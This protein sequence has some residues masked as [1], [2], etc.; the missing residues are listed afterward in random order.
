VLLYAVCSLEPEEGVET[1]AA[2]MG[3]HPGFSVEDPR[4]FLKDGA[5][6][7]VVAAGASGPVVMTRPDR[8]GMDGFFA[9][10]MRRQR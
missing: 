6:R 3:E 4:P 9:V 1:L 2:F 8:D 5:A 10:R 7:R